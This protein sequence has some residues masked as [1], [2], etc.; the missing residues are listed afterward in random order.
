MNKD[1]VIFMIDASPEMFQENDA[2]EVAFHSAVRGAIEMMTRK[3]ISSDS[4]LMGVCF[5]GTVGEL[6][7]FGS[8][9]T[10]ILS[11][12]VKTPMTLMGFMCS[13]TSTSLMLNAFCH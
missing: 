5:Y 8:V 2:G 7:V 1:A 9:L 4:D 11:E 12:N 3:I 10:V 6:L 13:L